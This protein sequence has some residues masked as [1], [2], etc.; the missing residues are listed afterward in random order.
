M[1]R[2]V[3]I[4]ILAIFVSTAAQ[5]TTVVLIDSN[6]N[7]VTTVTF[8]GFNWQPSPGFTA[9]AQTSPPMVAGGTFIAGVYTPPPV[10]S[11]ASVPPP[12]SVQV[13]ST[14][15]PALSGVYAFEA[16]TQS[17]ILAISLYISVNG[18]F[19]AGQTSFPWPD[20]SG[21]MHMFTTTAQ[22]QALA[23]ALA[24]YA[25]ALDLGQT[26]TAPVTIP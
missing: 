26:P 16:V 14:S 11:A 23:S 19:P 2:A 12:T 22:F 21:T 8:S 15:T 18:K 17:K 3:L 5:A 6:G 10:P 9:V 1:S 7:I 20:A 4:F 25:T 24:D 13:N